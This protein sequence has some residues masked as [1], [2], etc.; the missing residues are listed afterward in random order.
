MA[1]TAADPVFVDANVLVYARLTT[2]AWHADAVNALDGHQAAGRPL[3]TSRQVFR[4]YLATLTRPGVATP[5][6]PVASLVADVQGFTRRFTIA[7]DSATVTAQHLTLLST[8]TV[9]GKK[10]HD[11]NIV[12]TMLVYGVPNLLTHNVADFTRYA[13][14]ITII[15]LVPPAAPPPAPGA[16]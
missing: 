8:I 1:T 14:L 2:S 9:Q 5:M 12:A 6:P 10:V 16:P 3:W 13:H 15:P 4:E 11:A 7:E